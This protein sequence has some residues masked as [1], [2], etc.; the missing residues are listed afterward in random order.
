MCVCIESKHNILQASMSYALR[1]SKW[2]RQITLI[3]SLGTNHVARGVIKNKLS[4]EHNS[5]PN[6][7][8]HVYRRY[9]I[10]YMC[11]CHFVPAYI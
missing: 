9:I 4:G 7:T 6:L 11:I 2:G 1:I 8:Y 5:K 10:Y 3:C